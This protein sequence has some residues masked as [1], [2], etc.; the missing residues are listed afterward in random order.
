MAH[1]QAQGVAQLIGTDTTRVLHVICACSCTTRC[2]CC[3]KEPVT[4]RWLTG[5]LLAPSPDI[6][7]RSLRCSDDSARTPAGPQLRPWF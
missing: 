2:K 7:L 4:G 1:V 5:L 6:V 3:P